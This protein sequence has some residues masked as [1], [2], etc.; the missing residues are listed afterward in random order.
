MQDE[1]KQQFEDQVAKQLSQAA[2]VRDAAIAR[3]QE[4]EEK[5]GANK[6]ERLAK[7]QADKDQCEEDNKKKREELDEKI[8][9]IRRK[10][11]GRIDHAEDEIRETAEKLLKINE[12]I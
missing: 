4:A 12:M 6:E 1:K 8:A 5:N 3:L 7:A 9:D 10:D 2:E 11:D